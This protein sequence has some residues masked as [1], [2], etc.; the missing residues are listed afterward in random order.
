MAGAS[1]QIPI[2][3]KIN[4]L[5]YV[6]KPSFDVAHTPEKPRE[7]WMRE[8]A[9]LLYGDHLDILM[10]VFNTIETKEELEKAKEE[11]EKAKARAG[12][13]AEREFSFQQQRAGRAAER[14]FSFQQQRAGS[15]YFNLMFFLFLSLSS[16]LLHS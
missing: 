10:I 9:G 6:V 2:E 14:E 16:F 13:A 8:I 3:M 7:L 1:F 4:F 5:E 12:R 11:L 15:F